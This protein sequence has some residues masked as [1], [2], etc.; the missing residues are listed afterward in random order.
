MNKTTYFLLLS[1][2]TLLFL[3]CKTKTVEVPQDVNITQNYLIKKRL[4]SYVSKSDEK[5]LTTLAYEYPTSS[6]T[7]RLHFIAQIPMHKNDHL[8]TPNEPLYYLRITRHG[9]QWKE[10]KKITSA[11]FYG[12]HLQPR[13]SNIRHGRYFEEYTVEFTLKTLQNTPKETLHF[14]LYNAK[15]EKQH[16][17]IKSIYLDAFLKILEHESPSTLH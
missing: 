8:I 4:V 16:I 2:I 13:Y 9:Q 3:G 11:T 7:Y 6:A 1:F 10:F 17:S 15:K 12:L 14:T 5:I